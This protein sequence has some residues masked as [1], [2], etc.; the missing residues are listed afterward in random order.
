M[1]TC[2]F[3]YM[4]Q[5]YLA[6]CPFVM[7]QHFGIRFTL[8]CRSDPRV[9]GCRRL[10]VVTSIHTIVQFGYSASHARMTSGGCQPADSHWHGTARSFAGV[11]CVVPLQLASVASWLRPDSAASWL[12]PDSARCRRRIGVRDAACCFAA[13]CSVVAGFAHCRFGTIVGISGSVVGGSSGVEYSS[14]QIQILLLSGSPLYRV[15][16][17]GSS[18]QLLALLRVRRSRPF[19]ILLHRGSVLQGSD[20]R[21][22]VLR[23]LGHGELG[24]T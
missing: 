23:G 9:H 2:S 1:F 10:S 4:S 22:S 15:S 13:C 3:S 5:I 7:F 11:S 14:S 21:E 24:R 19:A 18:F 20:L 17:V 8:S 16:V 6:S 12:R